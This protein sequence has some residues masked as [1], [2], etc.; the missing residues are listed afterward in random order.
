M[1]FTTLTFIYFLLTLF[2]INSHNFTRPFTKDSEF[3]LMLNHFRKSNPFCDPKIQI[4]DIKKIKNIQLSKK[5]EIW[6]NCLVKK[7]NE[8]LDIYNYYTNNGDFKYLGPD[9]QLNTAFRIGLESENEN[10]NKYTSIYSYLP[11]PFD[12]VTYLNSGFFYGKLQDKKINNNFILQE[13]EI[14]YKINDEKH[15]KNPL[16]VATTSP[17]GNIYDFLNVKKYKPS[18]FILNLTFSSKDN[19]NIELIQKC[20]DYLGIQNLQALEKTF[21]NSLKKYDDIKFL[22]QNNKLK[23]EKNKNISNYLLEYSK[24]LQYKNNTIEDFYLNIRRSNITNIIM[25][26]NFFDVMEN[27]KSC[28]INSELYFG[29]HQGDVFQVFKSDKKTQSFTVKTSTLDHMKKNLDHRVLNY[30]IKNIEEEYEVNHYHYKGWDDKRLPE[31]NAYDE[32]VYLMDL[33]VQKRQRGENFIIHRDTGVGRTGTFIDN[34][35]IH[36]Y[37][38]NYHLYK[39]KRKI[40]EYILMNLNF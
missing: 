31:G 9:N 17:I 1:K 37:L 15:Q 20:V 35:L 21:N 40:L 30:K 8:Y 13:Y 39:K 11:N 6:N 27:Q 34:V 19:F 2:K 36:E 4:F 16:M 18:S 12:K 23:N 24:T 32:L 38:K 3:N 10:K 33:V 5:E 25:L 29:L 26:T 14:L 28:K 7:G 22:K